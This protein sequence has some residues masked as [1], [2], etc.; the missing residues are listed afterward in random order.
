MKKTVVVLAAAVLIAA[1][2]F[3]GIVIGR[4]VSG[5][6]NPGTDNNGNHPNTEPGDTVT[7]FMFEYKGEKAYSMTGFAY[8]TSSVRLPDG[9]TKIMCADGLGIS[10]ELLKSLTP[11][12]VYYDI[13]SDDEIL[14]YEYGELTDKPFSLWKADP[15]GTVASGDSVYTYMKE[16][17]GIY[18]LTVNRNYSSDD[19]N[20]EGM[21]TEG[22]CVFAEDRSDSSKKSFI[23]GEHSV[24]NYEKHDDPEEVALMYGYLQE[25][26]QHCVYTDGALY[27]NNKTFIKTCDGEFFFIKH[28]KDIN[29]VKPYIPCFRVQFIGEDGKSY[30][31]FFVE[32]GCDAYAFLKELIDNSVL[33]TKVTP[34][35]ADKEIIR[36]DWSDCVI[37]NG[38]VYE[39][40]Y[41][42][43]QVSEDRIGKKVGTV[44]KQLLTSIASEEMLRASYYTDCTAA[45]LPVLTE[46]YEV[47]DSEDIAALLNGNYFLYKKK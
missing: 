36:V 15:F 46:L 5:G 2:T 8:S 21:M 3:G 34:Q 25:M 20:E 22:I 1:M 41:A 30:A 18:Y 35:P 23:L 4:K 38:I 12:T 32:E 45:F 9:Q 28:C 42:T 47:K 27:D 44:K 7:S 29:G 33:P 6:N 19:G 10:D 16:N 17:P 11:P 39:G 37:L 31:I 24:C 13:S 40:N 26:K 43:E 14:Y